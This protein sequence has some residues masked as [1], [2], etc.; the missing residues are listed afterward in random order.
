M[1]E[2]MPGT[3]NALAA[4]NVQGWELRKYVLYKFSD[5]QDGRRG[6]HGERWFGG[7]AFDVTKRNGCLMPNIRSRQSSDDAYLMGRFYDDGTYELGSAFQAR[8]RQTR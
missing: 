2:L 8:A 6:G 4:N 1:D 7:T 5:G 3:I